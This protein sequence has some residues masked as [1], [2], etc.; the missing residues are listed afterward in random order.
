MSEIKVTKLNI[1]E[2]QP[3]EQSNQNF[4]V[5]TPSIFLVLSHLVVPAIVIGYL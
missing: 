1:D 2:K 3:K 5:D 4:F